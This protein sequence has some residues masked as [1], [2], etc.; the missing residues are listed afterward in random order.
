L[1]KGELNELVNHLRGGD[2]AEPWQKEVQ[3][4]QQKQVEKDNTRA[5][6]AEIDR[7]KAEQEVRLRKEAMAG[8]KGQK[9]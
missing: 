7:L 2:Q 6:Q 9:E 1:R 5:V 8:Q 4:E 3:E